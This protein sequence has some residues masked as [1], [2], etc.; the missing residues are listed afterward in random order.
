MGVSSVLRTVVALISPRAKTRE[1]RRRSGGH[2]KARKP[3]VQCSVSEQAVQPHEIGQFP[4]LET[5]VSSVLLCSSMA[6]LPPPFNPSEDVR[7]EYRE[8]PASSQKKRHC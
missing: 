6:L 3:D 4:C 1:K 7:P 8:Q 2:P 5:W